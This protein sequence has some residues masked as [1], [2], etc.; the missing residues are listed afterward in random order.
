MIHDPNELSEYL[1]FVTANLWMY[2]KKT[3]EAEGKYA[4]KWEELR[5]THETDGRTNMAVKTTYE[6]QEWRRAQVAEKTLLE[7]IRSLK[8]R[9]Q[10]LSDERM[11]L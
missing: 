9:L 11:A 10:S 6:Y 8:K 1:V 4:Q 2:G 5:L 7:I 3:I